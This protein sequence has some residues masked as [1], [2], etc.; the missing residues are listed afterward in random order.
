MIKQFTV[1]TVNISAKLR[2]ARNR[3]LNEC[4]FECSFEYDKNKLQLIKKAL[5]LRFKLREISVITN[6]KD[7]HIFVLKFAFYE[8]AQHE[9]YV[10]FDEQ[11]LKVIYKIISA[12]CTL[13][14][15][16]KYD[17]QLR[18]TDIDASI[19]DCLNILTQ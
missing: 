15:M 3:Q 17:T 16:Y 6:Y 12:V 8:Q 7:Y 1:N 4:A 14:Q 5:Q 10:T 18:H 9:F 13:Y 11:D 19:L 2:F